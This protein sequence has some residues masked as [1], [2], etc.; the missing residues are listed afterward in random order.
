M[1]RSNRNSTNFSATFDTAA[2]AAAAAASYIAPAVP[3]ISRIEISPD[4]LLE[5]IRRTLGDTSQAQAIIDAH[6]PEIK[7]R[8]DVVDPRQVAAFASWVASLTG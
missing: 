5:Q 6:W 2:A 7:A 3:E 4:H 1:G 8:A